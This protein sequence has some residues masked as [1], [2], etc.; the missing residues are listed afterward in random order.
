M[1]AADS[2]FRAAQAARSDVLVV[3]HMVAYAR[4]I[5]DSVGAEHYLQR[6]DRVVADLLVADKAFEEAMR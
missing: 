5:G 2:E 3:A 1:T 6:L 4:R